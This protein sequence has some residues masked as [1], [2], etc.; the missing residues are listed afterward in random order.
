MKVAVLSESAADEAAVLVLTKAILGVEI[1]RVH[2]PALRTRGW[3]SVLDAL[4]AVL[5]YLH[6]RT[7]ADGLI[8]VVDS[9]NSEVHEPTHRETVNPRCRLCRLCQVTDRTSGQLSPVAGRSRLKVAIG[10]AVPCI[11]AWYSGGVDPRVSEAAWRQ[12]LGTGLLLYTKNALKNTVYGTERPTLQL[13]TTC[14]TEAA[15]RLAQ[16]LGQLTDL[17]PNTVGPLVERVKTWLEN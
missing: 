1:E 11:E 8:V 16:N 5:K 3:P 15:S 7:D 4:P 6:Y 9:N 17:F 12:G 10:V 2:G 14:A 13:E